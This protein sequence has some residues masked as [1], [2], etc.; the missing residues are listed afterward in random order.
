M[1]PF[2]NRA[3][4]AIRYAKVQLQERIWLVS[5]G[6][7]TNLSKLARLLDE[8]AHAI[9]LVIADTPGVYIPVKKRQKGGDLQVKAALGW[10][11]AR[12]VNQMSM[13]KRTGRQFVQ[14]LEPLLPRYGRT[15]W[16]ESNGTIKDNILERGVKRHIIVDL[17]MLAGF[18]LWKERYTGEYSQGRW[19]KGK[20]QIVKQ[21]DQR[22]KVTLEQ[23]EFPS[24]D[25]LDLV[26]PFPSKLKRQLM[27]ASPAGELAY[28]SLEMALQQ[29]LEQ[30]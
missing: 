21:N 3:P 22:F 28:R 19:R 20:E 9:A 25:R 23:L 7:W 8:D 13:N 2:R 24:G 11:T 16:L 14:A 18:A 5:L 10:M 26:N 1:S 4:S 30:D 12:L 15:H 6:K 29:K 17:S 27:E